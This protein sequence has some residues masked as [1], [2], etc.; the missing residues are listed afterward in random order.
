MKSFFVAL[1]RRIRQADRPPP[2]RADES[3]PV[4]H[5]RNC[6]H[7]MVIGEAVMT[8]LTMGRPVSCAHCGHTFP[9]WSKT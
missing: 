6:D 8:A 2:L 5:C 1:R 9:R 3:A 4:L 7:T